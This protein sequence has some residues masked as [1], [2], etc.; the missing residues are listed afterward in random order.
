MKKITYKPSVLIKLSI[1]MIVI[2]G[3][4]SILSISRY[5]LF[6]FLPNENADNY[7]NIDNL[8]VDENTKE[9]FSGR[10][11]TNNENGFDIYSYKNGVM[12]GL[13]VI[14]RN[15][16]L[17]EVG[18]WKND[19]QNGLFIL[20]TDNGVLVDYANFKNGKRHGKTKQY[21]DHGDLVV[22]VEYNNGM[23]ETAKQYYRNGKPLTME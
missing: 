3:L 17:K 6:T 4:F 18:H 10:L 23:I 5:K 22:E 9:P 20:Y 19:L 11:K 2:V 8:E 16:R 7:I 21:N 12:N 1:T 14:Y 13:N 15:G